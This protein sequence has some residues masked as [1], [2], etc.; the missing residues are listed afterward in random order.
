MITFSFPFMVTIED[1]DKNALERAKFCDDYLV[2]KEI[3]DEGVIRHKKTNAIV[4]IYELHWEKAAD[5]VNEQKHILL[6]KEKIYK[7]DNRIRQV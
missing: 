4:C 2:A 3:F 6:D 1:F 5:G 7:N